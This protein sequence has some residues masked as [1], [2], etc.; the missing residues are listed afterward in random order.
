[1]KKVFKLDSDSQRNS[2][3]RSKVPY[4]PFHNSNDGFV[5]VIVVVDYVH[6]RVH[7]R[8]HRRLL[9]FLLLLLLIICLSTNNKQ[10]SPSLLFTVTIDRLNFPI[11]SVSVCACLSLFEF[12]VVSHVIHHIAAAAAAAFPAALIYD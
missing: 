8:R 11:H 3:I 6:I 9:W 12:S 5:V 2:R 10:L 1:M 4:T 7:F